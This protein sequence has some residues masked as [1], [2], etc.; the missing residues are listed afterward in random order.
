MRQTDLVDQYATFYRA[1]PHDLPEP[2][3]TSKPL[4]LAIDAVTHSWQSIDHD[5]LL[6]VVAG[7][8]LD[9][10]WRILDGATHRGFVVRA[11]EDFVGRIQTFAETV[12]D[13]L[14]M[15]QCRSERSILL[16]RR[17]TLQQMARFYYLSHYTPLT[18]QHL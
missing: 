6:L 4:M 5:D 3:Q 12:V 8:V 1:H 16:E 9:E 15:Q 18:E 13:W 17:K 2:Y 11:T 14:Y 7:A 10:M